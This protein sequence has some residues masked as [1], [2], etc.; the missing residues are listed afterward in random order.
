MG[1]N[2]KN[3]ETQ[4][5]ARKLAELTGETLTGA[6]TT[7]LRE[8]LDRVNREKGNSLSARLLA[9]GRECAAHLEEP[10]R[11]VDHGELLYDEKGLPK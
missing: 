2:I 4:E 9:I 10:Y 8:R 11:S 6:I 5:L 3:Q 7:A 1:L